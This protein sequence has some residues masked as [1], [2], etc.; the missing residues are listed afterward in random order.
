MYNT[1]MNKSHHARGIRVAAFAAAA[2]ILLAATPFARAS[3]A[4]PS[5]L[6]DATVNLFCKLKVGNKVIVTTGTGSF[7]SERGVILTNAHV[8]QYFLAIERGK[9]KGDCSVRAG[10]P[11]KRS[12]QASV[13]YFPPTW[14]SDNAEGIRSNSNESD[15]K[16]DFA[17]LYVTG[18]SGPFPY[19]AYD[20]ALPLKVGEQVAFAGYPS[21]GLSYRKILNALSLVTSS[22]TVTSVRSY[23][24]A[25]PAN[26]PSYMETVLK[27]MGVMPSYMPQSHAAEPTDELIALAPADG[28]KSGVSGAAIVD[29]RNFVR[30]VITSKGLNG[31]M[32]T[33]GLSLPYVSRTVRSYTG[34]PLELFLSGDYSFRSQITRATIPDNDIDSVVQGLRKVK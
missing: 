16:R 12:Y 23:A 7:I 17:L 18:Q 20:A 24:A 15:G 29:G 19:L 10:S 2:A 25:S 28:A 14:L 5:P 8:A 30:G 31:T 21:E 32:S 9:L 34:L 13:L 11:A 4:G 27:E 6:P 22:T 3:A 26:S 1:V 33:Y